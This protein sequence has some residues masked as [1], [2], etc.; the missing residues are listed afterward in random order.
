[1]IEELDIT[2]KISVVGFVW[3]PRIGIRCLGTPP[4]DRHFKAA[5]YGFVPGHGSRFLPQPQI[6]DLKLAGIQG[7]TSK[8]VLSFD[9]GERMCHHAGLGGSKRGAKAAKEPPVRSG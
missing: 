8:P 4:D 3:F 6:L 1:M 5:L 2:Y 9:T 7:A